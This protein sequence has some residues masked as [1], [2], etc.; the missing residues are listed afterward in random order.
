MSRDFASFRM[1]LVENQQKLSSAFEFQEDEKDI[2]EDRNVSSTE[3]DTKSFSEEVLVKVEPLDISEYNLLVQNASNSCLNGELTIK[4]K[5]MQIN[6][7][8][9]SADWS[10]T[11]EPKINLSNEIQKI[12][13]GK[14]EKGKKKMCEICGV[15]FNPTYFKRHYE[16]MHLKQKCYC[17]DICGFRVYKKFD[18]GSHIKTHFKV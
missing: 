17:C 18:M 5:G 9:F 3:N 15:W 2:D 8:N 7:F 4:S 11:V 12:P 13:Q 6:N 10:E 1:Q 16:R 14:H